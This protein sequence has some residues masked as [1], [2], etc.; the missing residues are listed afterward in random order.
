M[1]NTFRRNIKSSFT[2][3]AILCCLFICFS[4][5]PTRRLAEDEQLFIRSKVLIDK[6]VTDQTTLR[7]YER[8]L[9]NKT[10]LGV[11]FHL[12]LYSIAK[13]GKETWPHA[14]LRKIGEPP[15]LYDSALVASTRKNFASYLSDKGYSQV[16]V[17]SEMKSRKKKVK[18][19]YRIDPGEPTLI[20]SLQYRL[21][22]TSVAK[23][24]L[25]DTLNSLIRLNEP[26][27]KIMMMQERLRIE[28]Q[29]KNLGYY[30]FTRE[31]VYYEVKPLS[32]PNEV[33]VMLVV[34]QDIDSPFDP[35]SKVRKHRQF[36]V[37]SVEI[38]PSYS[39]AEKAISSDTLFYQQHQIVYFNRP[40][41]RAPTLVAANN[42]LPGS[43]YSLKNVERTYND[44]TA[45]GLFRYMNVSMKE[46][47]SR[48]QYGLLDC[49]IDLDMR[50]K[51]SYALEFNVTNSSYDFGI[52]GGITYNNY[53][54]FRNGEHL[55]IRTTGSVESLE[56][57]Q[58]VTEPMREIG[59]A[60][61]FETPRFLLPFNAEDFERKYKPRTQLQS[62]YNY[63]NQPNYIRTIVNASFGYNWKGNVYNRHVLKPF[64]FYLVK[65]P[66]INQEYIDSVYGN[67]RLENSFINH[68]ILGINYSFEFNNQQLKRGNSFVYLR[69]NIESA[70]LLL[71]VANQ[72]GNWSSD[73]LF[74]GVGYFQ[75]IK[76]D[77]DFRNYNIITP[78]NRVVYRIF[79]GIG[80]PYG[81]SDAMPFEKMYW[82][83]GPYGIRAWGERT[84]GPGPYFGYGGKNQSGEEKPE[85]L[86]DIKLEGNIEYRFKLFWKLEGALFADAGNI[87]LLTDIPEY[88]GSGF[89][90]D[91]FYK[92]IALGVGFGTRFDFSFVLLRVD[93]GFKMYDP[94]ITSGTRWV[95]RN[96]E[97]NFWQS[98]FQF[99][100]GYP[101]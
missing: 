10:V 23:H 18:A 94:S 73:S 24:F 90:L 40:V 27:D 5:A 54:L 92:D 77:I 19:V 47:D 81:N 56:N 44:L 59:L 76:T 17:E 93:I 45:L 48:G 33:S 35:V 32:N 50:K 57:R 70:G 65:L 7:K 36:K 95:I 87:W 82:A 28:T 63:Q 69:Y 96:P 3:A 13:P 55:Q 61:L 37:N 88:P 31:H 66:R 39:L 4:C 25:S 85:P 58:N 67:T 68:T 30:R 75:Y 53:N 74:F 86:G 49:R 11:R 84:L 43:I 99:G 62:S 78:R 9:P 22:D 6:E 97:R 2:Q 60:G 16:E 8:M 38:Y 26:F 21:E 64:D 41:L 101:F 20:K 89:H 52:S 72:L 98:T 91:T 80:L 51:Q 15:V 71:N 12:Y 14:W 1:L 79:A 34:K 100:I 42:I 83:G 29:M 46:S